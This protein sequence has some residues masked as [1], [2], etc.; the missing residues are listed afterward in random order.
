MNWRRYLAGLGLV[1]LLL[2]SPT[3]GA[4]A[5]WP[6]P[7]PDIT[8]TDSGVLV[9]WHTPALQLRPQANGTWAVAWPGAPLVSEPGQPRLP[10]TAMLVALPP[11]A[12]ATVRVLHR[13]EQSRLLPGPLMINP[14]PR[15]V[16]RDEAGVVMGGAFAPAVPTPFAYDWIELQPLGVVRGV[17]LARLVIYPVRL[18]GER[19]RVTTHLKAEV[20]FDVSPLPPFESTDKIEQLLRQLVINPTQLLSDPAG[21]TP[22]LA[23]A[24]DL[25]V[26]VNTP[27]VTALTY[28]A[29][30]SSGLAVDAI[31]P[32]HLRLA[33]AGHEIA[34]E[35]DG[36]ADGQFEPGERLLF[37]AAPRFSRWLNGDV[38]FLSDIGAPVL[39]MTTR[40]ADPTG[41]PIG[42]AWH[43]LAAESNSFY[44]PECYCAPIPPG[45]DGDRWTWADL[46]QPGAPLA[47]FPFEVPTV[48]ASQ[49]AT[50]TMWLIG[51]TSIAA[52]TP[53]H[54]V[55][56][57]LNGSPLGNVAWDSKQA[58][59]ATLPIT[60]GLLLSGT[61]VLSLT[62]P[63]LPGV[64]VEGEWLDAFLIRYAR[65]SGASG[66]AADFEGE[67]TT[68]AY[69]LALTS[70]VGLR[71]YDVT[72][73]DQPARLTDVALLSDTVMLA[74]A[75]DNLGHRYALA[76]DNAIQAPS[77][78]RLTTPLPT[79]TGADYLIITPAEF[80]PA[81]SDWV[82]LRQSQNLNV[83]VVDVQAIY[84]AVDGRPTP[85]AIRAYLADAYAN[86]TPRP[87]Y[88]LLVGD[89]TS[90]PKHY[91]TNTTTTFIPPYLEDVDPW[92]DETAA[93]NRYVTLDGADLLPDMAIGRWPVN[94][95]TE[96]QIIAD[97]VVQYEATPAPGSWNH[98][99]VFVADNADAGG[100]FPAQAQTLAATWIPAPFITQTIFYTPPTTTV[101]ATQQSILTHWNMGVGLLAY[102]GH[103]STHQWAAERFIHDTEVSGLTNRLRQPVVLEMTCFTGSFQTPGLPTL[104]ET[105]LRHTEGGA[106][107]VWGATGLGVST[108][109]D[110]LAEGF[111]RD[112]Y[113]ER[114]PVVGLAVLAGKLNLA[115]QN[116][117]FPDLIDTF[118]LLGD[119]ALAFDLASH[120]L[121]L[122][123]LHR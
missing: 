71:V 89:G 69:S 97:K 14:Q 74:D 61:N 73:A 55:D 32:A 58:I 53:D 24:G 51:Y 114:Q 115:T 91:R 62:L 63:G 33:R 39:R 10:M 72:S 13:D 44:T 116:P 88:V 29:L 113:Q 34:L 19:L 83:A 111:L 49:P 103:A 117:S 105:L 41:L 35:W 75:D 96:T 123:L 67:P 48:E 65:G 57:S 47:A 92:A 21:R 16:R 28:D 70:T 118:T 60:P 120:Q 80:I 52:V 26:E 98:E 94:T 1:G 6:R 2:G 95:F 54:R 43:A 81:L 66:G 18:D 119:P 40:S 8:V 106:V 93:D 42:R 9:E 7:T 25:A 38:Y 79:I 17:N 4:S 68:H 12:S 31:N 102:F 100:N 22:S 76:A 20:L 107:A 82:T 90:D 50:L 101:T 99:L 108:G 110:L 46:R 86:W 27:G 78:L 3:A 112:V 59:T 104:D 64:A 5:A 37:Y 87:T 84:D 109:H 11:G 77:R 122:P 23:T 56:V 121:Y 45:R 85:E 30:A 15:D 36:D